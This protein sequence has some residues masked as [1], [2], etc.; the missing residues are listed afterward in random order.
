MLLALCTTARRS[1]GSFTVTRTMSGSGLAM[2]LLR[3][4]YGMLTRLAYS[5][6]DC[7]LDTKVACL[8]RGSAVNCLVMASPSVLSIS[9]TE[10][11]A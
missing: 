4:L 6:R 7:S 11:V 5:S 3:S 1:S 2:A 9:S 10:M 8:T